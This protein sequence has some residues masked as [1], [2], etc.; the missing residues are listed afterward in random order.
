MTPKEMLGWGAFALATIGAIVYSVA[1]DR[2]QVPLWAPVAEQAAPIVEA[3]T[4][5]PVALEPEPDCGA[6]I[7]KHAVAKLR[8]LATVGAAE[9]GT[10]DDRERRTAKGQ[11]LFRSRTCKQSAD[12]SLRAPWD[13]VETVTI[14]VSVCLECGATPEQRKPKCARALQALK[15]LTR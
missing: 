2:A 11:V 6:D 10:S 12:E 14:D 13:T 3:P 5:S 9:C 15:G 7:L 4:P 1:H 8:E